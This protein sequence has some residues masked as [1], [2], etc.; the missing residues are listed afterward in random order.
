MDRAPR[1]SL[2]PLVTPFKGG[3]I[4]YEGFSTLL[5]RQIDAG[6]HGVV[7]A[8]TSGEPGT[9]S[10]EEREQLAECAVDTAGGRLPVI[11]GTGTSDL[12]QTLRLTKQAEK[13]G[14]S[15]ALVV[16]PYYVRPSQHG[17]VDYFT[18]VAASTDLP[19]I[20]Y[21]IPMRTGTALDLETI[22]TLS[23]IEN[24]VGVKE[25][26]TD[27]EHVT[28]VIARCG[29]DFAVY[30]G[31]ETLCLPVL[32][33]GGAGHVSATG[34]IAPR[35]MADLANA[36]FSGDWETARTLHF[37]LLELNEAVFADTNPVPMK[38][39]L[40]ELGLIDP[41]VRSPLAPLLPAAREQ[42][43]AALT[44]FQQ[45]SPSSRSND[46]ALANSEEIREIGDLPWR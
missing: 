4:D 2:P 34:N 12:R 18:K 5:E 29:P 44:E 22:V 41:E 23:E 40:G 39:M 1:G 7:V 21:D 27:L 19:V 16:T 8:G 43:L 31:L 38:T 42:V 3:E 11:V 13:A 26:R 20:L 9:L 36:A 14:A 46:P 32:I 37:E 28:R 10:L 45:K 25:T 30:C 15:A 6:S 24:V 33:L 35:E 17:I